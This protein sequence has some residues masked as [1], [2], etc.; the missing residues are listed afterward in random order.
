VLT[1]LGQLLGSMAMM[2]EALK[3]CS[4]PVLIDT[5]GQAAGYWF[6]KLSGIRVVAYVHY[7]FISTDM[8]Q[9][10]REMR[11]SYNN[12]SKIANIRTVSYLKIFYYKILLF[13]YSIIGS[14]CDLALCNS[15]WT[16]N[17]IQA[18]W[19]T[20][21]KVIYPPCD[22]KVFLN[23][24]L[25]SPSKHPMT[26]ISIGQFRPEKDHELQLRSLSLLIQK[27]PKFKNSKLLL[28][29]SSRNEEDN[30]RVNYLKQKA[31]ELGIEKQ[32]EFHLNVSFAEL[33]SLVEKSTVGLHSM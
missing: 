22:I 28:V 4:V 20:T 27:N 33:L 21:I 6:A 25:N 9:R 5:H 13:L 1:L 16:R 10:V 12:N 17:H 14:C 29:G 8:I 31:Q 23:V 2:M 18:L 3:K 30:A 24:P 7:P 26:A 11:P 19:K 32:V 15:S